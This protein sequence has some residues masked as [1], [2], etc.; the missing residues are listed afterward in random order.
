MATAREMAKAKR[1][2][3]ILAAAATIMAEKG[4]HQTRLGDVEIGRAH[5]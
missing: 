3:E 5:V 4:F 1:R 2:Q